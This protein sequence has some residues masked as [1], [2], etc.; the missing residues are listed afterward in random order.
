MT[1]DEVM[2]ELDKTKVKN[3]GKEDPSVV[4]LQLPMVSIPL[5]LLDGQVILP[6][7]TTVHFSF[8][9]N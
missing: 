3:Y 8:C 7:L 4:S 9:L 6:I 5:C 1:P 2:L